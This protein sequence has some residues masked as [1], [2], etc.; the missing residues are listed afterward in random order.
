MLLHP[1][2]HEIPALA[3]GQIKN[4]FKYNVLTY[5]ALHTGHAAYLRACLKPYTSSERT[6]GSDPELVYLGYTKVQQ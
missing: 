3:V 4:Q 5:K 6:R 1:F 2:I